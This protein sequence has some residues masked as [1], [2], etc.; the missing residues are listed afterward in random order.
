MEYL[1][2]PFHLY[3]VDEYI[4]L[5]SNYIQLLRKDIVLDRFT[6]QS[7]SHMLITPKWGMKNHEFADKLNNYLRQHNIFQGARHPDG[8]FTPQPAL[9]EK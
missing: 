4:H 6:S 8:A 5:I 2:S 3:S 7:P 9:G 1:S